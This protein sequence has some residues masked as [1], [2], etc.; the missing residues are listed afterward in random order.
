MLI[1]KQIK[2]VKMT[3]DIHGKNNFISVIGHK[4]NVIG[5]VCEKC[6]EKPHK[7]NCKIH[8][9]STFYKNNDNVF[10]CKRCDTIKITICKYHG[11]TDF[12][13]NNK[14]VLICKKC[15]AYNT[16]EH[17]RKLKQ[18]AV[19]LFGGK[20]TEC[21][22]S[23]CIAALDFHHVDKTKKEFNIFGVSKKSWR[24]I[25]EELKKCILLCSNCHR[26]HHWNEWQEEINKKEKKP[27]HFDEWSEQKKERRKSKKINRYNITPDFIKQLR[28]D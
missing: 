13:L 19:E 4:E 21:G 18:K 17:R 27:E 5:H 22:Y 6:S 8:G 14:G 12:V 20:C 1:K 9:V 23:K 3:C 26:E 25:V 24:K 2:P 28:E 11:K 7:R 16:S 10:C 15:R